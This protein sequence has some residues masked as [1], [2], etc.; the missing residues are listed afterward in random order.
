MSSLVSSIKNIRTIK[1]IRGDSLT[2]D[3]GKSYTGT[4]KAWMKKSPNAAT[5]RSFEVREGRFLFLDKTKAS[6]YYTDQGLLLER[7][8]GRWYFDVELIPEGEVEANSIT[9][10]TGVILFSNDITGSNS[11]EVTDPNTTPGVREYLHLRDTPDTYGTAGQVPSVNSE[12]TALIWADLPENYELINNLNEVVPGKVLDA[13]QG[14][15][16][17]DSKISIADVSAYQGK[18]YAVGE[19]LR[20]SLGVITRYSEGQTWLYV[21][22]FPTNGTFTCANFETEF[23]GGRWQFLSGDEKF[24]E[25]RATMII[26]G[27]GADYPTAAS[28]ADRFTFLENEVTAYHVINNNVYATISNTSYIAA[29]QGF[30][31]NTNLTRFVEKGALT[32]LRSNFLFNCINVIYAEALGATQVDT[33]AF[34]NCPLLSADN[35]KLPAVT[36]VTGTNTFRRLKD[37]ASTLSLPSLVTMN[38]GSIGSET[39]CRKLDVPNLVSVLGGTF[40]NSTFEEIYAP[41]LVNLGIN[42]A[43]DEQVFGNMSGAKITVSPL[44]LT[45]NAGQPDPDIVSAAINN[46]IVYADRP[47]VLS[48]NNTDDVKQFDVNLNTESIQFA[49]GDFNPTE[50]RFTAI[51]QTFGFVYINSVSG[52]DTTA[53]FFNYQKP[54]RTLTAAA[55]AVKAHS[56]GGTNICIYDLAD[57]GTYSFNDPTANTGAGLF[58][59]LNIISNTNSTFNFDSGAFIL[60]TLRLK[61]LGT[62]NFNYT[63]NTV[64]YNNATWFRM[65][66][67]NLSIDLET[68]NFN[69]NQTQNMPQGMLNGGIGGTEVEKFRLGNTTVADR[70]KIINFSG[71]HKGNA[72]IRIDRLTDNGTGAS[73]TILPDFAIK[74]F[75]IG[76]YIN[77]S[78]TFRVLYN[79][80][81]FEIERVE[82]NTLTWIGGPISNV[83]LIVTL[84]GNYYQN[85]VFWGN[86]QNHTGFTLIQGIGQEIEINRTTDHHTVEPGRASQGIAPFNYELTRKMHLHDLFIKVTSTGVTLTRPFIRW[87]VRSENEGSQLVVKDINLTYPDNA[88]I[89]E[90]INMGTTNLANYKPEQI[91]F[92]GTNVFD[93]GTGEFIKTRADLPAGLPSNWIVKHSGASVY[94]RSQTYGNNANI[95]SIETLQSY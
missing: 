47:P 10:Y 1:A 45:I 19:V 62:T 44:V 20:P 70:T 30:S 27:V 18:A 37:D 5:Y 82:G 2:I 53:E 35:I 4:L 88:P 56:S 40:V 11:V 91:R 57:N 72:K 7:V 69:N 55:L 12:G 58:N 48:V 42:P 79:K 61:I 32:R 90:A 50:K 31:N 49:G 3:L 76:T 83:S 38:G 13:T 41:K 24:F 94:H 67:R 33:G 54:Y 34:F 22:D 6:D 9:I 77:N 95:P 81:S 92:R 63:E 80:G 17:N 21:G 87:D 89:A 15:I 59:E 14:K 73:P 25:D 26:N 29:S 93:N 85:V 36:L 52:N 28:L 66:N 86:P 75:S 64:L 78:G 68:P 71:N 39:M 84:L 74:N 65:P 23:A 60:N 51:G 16:L 43:T 8:E 46:T